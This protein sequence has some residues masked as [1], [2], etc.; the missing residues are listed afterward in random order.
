MT[1]LVPLRLTGPLMLAT[2]LCA[3]VHA[4]PF[5]RAD[6]PAL[7]AATNTYLAAVD[8]ARALDTA[9]VPSTRDEAAV[10]RR[11]PS[12]PPPTTTTR[13]PTPAHPTATTPPTCCGRRHHHTGRSRPL[14]HPPNSTY[15]HRPNAIGLR[16]LLPTATITP[17]TLDVTLTG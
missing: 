16:H 5:L 7:L 3:S 8:A 4:P 13:P 1:S 2:V 10:R 9:L 12:T 6:M 14:C 17:A 11:Q 15:P